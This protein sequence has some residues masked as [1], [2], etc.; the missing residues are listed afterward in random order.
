MKKKDIRVPQELY[1]EVFEEP[2]KIG[3]YSFSPIAWK[4]ELTVKGKS[5]LCT[6]SHKNPTT[7]DWEQKYVSSCDYILPV[8]PSLWGRELKKM[9]TAYKGSINGPH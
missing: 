5:T 3:R 6:I 8:A 7:L 1:M 2:E 4:I 9:L